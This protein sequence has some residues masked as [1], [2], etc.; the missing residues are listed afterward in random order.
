[1]S[2]GIGGAIKLWDVATHEEI[3]TFTGHEAS[4]TGLAFSPDAAI[5][6]S[7]GRDGAIKLW[8]VATRQR[9]PP[10]RDTRPT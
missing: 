4:L 6:A 10:S 5:L 2:G 3:A 9:S 8:E 1:M 7:G